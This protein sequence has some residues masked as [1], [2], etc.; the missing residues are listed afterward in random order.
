MIKMWFVH[1]SRIDLVISKQKK[2]DHSIESI[3]QN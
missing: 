3:E 1:Y 2:I